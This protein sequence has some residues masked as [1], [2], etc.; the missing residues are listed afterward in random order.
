MLSCSGCKTSTPE[1][2]DVAGDPQSADARRRVAAR[3]RSRRRSAFGRPWRASVPAAA[4]AGFW[5][6]MKTRT[7]STRSPAWSTA[8]S[9]AAWW[10]ARSSTT[11]SAGSSISKPASTRVATWK[12]FLDEQQ[13]RYRDQME[14]YASI[15][16]PLGNPVRLGLYFPLF[17]EWREWTPG[18]GRPPAKLSSF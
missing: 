3:P 8:K 14:R 1:P 17:D 5:S 10:I 18:A 16:A 9:C 6:R 12:Q 4:A 11:A 13:R 15:L 7:P 2:P